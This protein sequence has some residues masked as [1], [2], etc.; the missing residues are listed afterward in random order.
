[1]TTHMYREIHEIPAV[2]ARFLAA[3]QDNL[4]QTAEMLRK[5][6]PTHLV[7]V[8]RGSSDHAATFIKYVCEL[9]LGLPVASVGPS[10]VSVYDRPISTR[11]GACLA[12]SQSGKSPD[13]VALAAHFATEGA[14]LAVLTNNPASPL[15]ALTAHVIALEAGPELSVAA[16]KS[17]VA[18]V[19]AGLAL[20]AEWSGDV[21]LTAG[22]AAL[23]GHLEQALK[24]DL[25]AVYPALETRGPVLIFGRGA[26]LAIAH[27]TALKLKETCG[28]QAEAYSSAE[29]R[30]G[31]IEMVDNRFTAIGLIQDGPSR[32]GVLETAEALRAQGARVFLMSSDPS[33][34]LGSVDTGSP[35]TASLCQIVSLYLMIEN[36]SHRLG[37]NPDQPKA[38]RKVTETV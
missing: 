7:T 2:A 10:V 22:L 3:Q 15:A 27:E 33:D 26:G 19:V 32:A 37:R 5:A 21:G 35:F 8:A 29:L 34:D 17:F 30:H 23:P 6:Q 36:L 12:F 25:S 20:L 13:I 11:G 14:P 24:I 28:L 31:P 16:T 4:R 38:L 18:T 9:V 1:M